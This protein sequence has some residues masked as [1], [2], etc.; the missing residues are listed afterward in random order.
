LA[1]EPT[2]SGQPARAPEPAVEPTTAP[3]TAPTTGDTVGERQNSSFLPAHVLIANALLPW[4]NQGGEVAQ[5]KPGASDISLVE[6]D[7]HQIDFVFK[8][9]AETPVF[10]SSDGG[11]QS[12]T[13]P[14]L[15][16]SGALAILALVGSGL[17]LYRRRAG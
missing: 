4:Q 8:E 1:S 12:L 9:E 14:V 3:T 17:L 5:A 13:T 16:G 11:T 15:L 10:A 6:S 7:E 2:N